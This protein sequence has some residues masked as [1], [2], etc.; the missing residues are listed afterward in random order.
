M[1]RSAA[2]VNSSPDHQTNILKAVQIM[3]DQLLTLKPVKLRSN[4][5]VTIPPG[6]TLELRGPV[7]TCDNELPEFHSLRVSARS[8][9]LLPKGLQVSSVQLKE[10][11]SVPQVTV[12][13]QNLNPRHSVQVHSDIIFAELE[14]ERGTKEETV[15]PQLLEALVGPSCESPVAINDIDTKCLLDSG[16]QVTVLSEQFYRK[17]LSHFPLKDLDT[18]LHITG[19]GGQSVPYL[20]IVNVTLTLPKTVA[21]TGS[22][23]NTMVFVC[24]DTDFSARVPLIVGTNVFRTLASMEERKD[25]TK[26]FDNLPPTLKC[27]AAFMYTDSISEQGSSGRL[28]PVRLRGKDCVIPA[29][30]TIDVKGFS[31]VTVP[32]TRDSVLIQEPVIQTLPSGLGVVS[33][34]VNVDDLFHVK[35]SLH[36][37]SDHDIVLRKK[38][39]IADVFNISAEY[40]VDK[41][42]S[43]LNHHLVGKNDFSFQ[44]NCSLSAGD[45]T[46]TTSEPSLSNSKSHQYRF[47]E[48]TPVDWQ[49]SFSHRLT[50]YQDVFIKHD[51]D[52]GC[53]FG[54]EHDIELTPG[55]TIRERPRPVAP[56][57]LEE[58]KKHIQDLLD[59]QIISPSTSSFASPIVL[60]RKKSGALRMCVDY[61]KLNARTMKDAYS[62][63]KIED[64]FLTLSGAK[65]FTSVDLSKA[66]YQVPMTDRAKQFSAFTT[67]LGLFQWERMSMGLTNAPATF[68]RLMETV[69][70]DMNLMELIV[71]LDD[72]LIHGKTLEE[73][74]ERT[75]NV[76][77]RLR[78]FNLKLDPAKCIFGATEVKHLGYIVSDEGIRPDP[79]KLEA[80]KTWP[81]PKTVKELKSFLGFASFYRRFVNGFARIAKPLHELTSGYTPQKGKKGRQKSTLTLSS[82]ISH[83]IEPKHQVAFRELVTAL[84]SAPILGIADKSNPFELHCD[85]SGTGLGAVLYQD[86]GDGLKVIAYAS[87]GLT[88][89]EQNYP[90][91]KREFLALK[92]AMSE[93]FHDYLY[94]SP[95]TVVTD[96]NPLC[97]VL[98]NAKLD[99]TSHRWLTTLSLYDFELRYK[100]GALHQDADG[101][102]RRPQPSPEED[103]EYRKTLEKSAFL[104]KKAQQFD[105]E[106]KHQTH[107]VNVTR[108]IIQAILVAKG[109]TT[110]ASCHQHRVSCN[111]QVDAE[112]CELNNWS[113]AVEQIIK[114][115][116]KIEDHVLE[117]PIQ[118]TFSLSPDEWKTLQRADKTLQLVINHVERGEKLELHKID[119]VTPELRVFARE[120]GKLVL[121]EGVLY[122]KTLKEANARLQLVIPSSHRA[123]AMKGVHDDLF[124]TH[125]EDSLHQA[126]LRFYWPFMARDLERK[127]KRCSRCIRRGAKFQKAPMHSIVT[128]FPLE[129]LSIDFLTIEVKGGKQNILVVMDHFTKF[130][131][132]ILTK[133]QTAKTVA[134]ALWN[135]FFMVYGF[136]MRILSDQGRDFE[137]NLIK[138][139]CSVAGIQ[140]CRTSP[141]HP[142]SNPVERWNR[143]LITM[144]RS[145]EDCQKTDW[146]KHIKSCVH[147]YNA[148]IHQSTGY[149]PYYLFFGR[150]PRLPIDLAFG[151]ETVHGST[152]IEYIRSLKD[153][154]KSAYQLA[155]DN[156]AK[157]AKRNK[158]RYDAGAHAAELEPGDRVLVKKLGPKITSKVDDRWERS[159]YKI[160]SKSEDL[161]VYVVEREDGIG[162]RR[163]LHRNL[164]LPIG[165]LELSESEHRHVVHK[166]SR[167]RTVGIPNQEE[168][169]EEEM[170]QQTLIVEVGSA[171]T[172]ELRAEAP[173]FVP[174]SVAGHDSNEENSDDSGQD[175]Q[176]VNRSNEEG[177]EGSNRE[178]EAELE[179]SESRCQMAEQAE[180]GGEEK[181]GSDQEEKPELEAS[182]SR[183]RRTEQAEEGE[184]E[185]EEGEINQHQN[186]WESEEEENSVRLRRSTRTR[187]PV[188]R[189]NLGHYCR[190]SPVL[191]EKT[192]SKLHVCMSGKLPDEAAFHVEKA[193]HAIL[194]MLDTWF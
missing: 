59:A 112:V 118:R 148:C 50:Q 146:R 70:R 35:V 20:G 173:E 65:Y 79:E 141:Y 6:D 107:Q 88:K 124:H 178:E 33:R 144:L 15:T 153:N 116:S 138:E 143:T 149:S 7:T 75:I 174:N 181:E 53:T 16:S 38:Q 24:K 34:K 56:K 96:N 103:E 67:P 9:D 120:Q 97:Y 10:T 46:R 189:L 87:R 167:N 135:D 129:L 68:Q 36:N 194:Q 54:A 157:M 114:D 166:N 122:R 63:P 29:G 185:I 77:E 55:L 80:L 17:H 117:P 100:R 42:F 31:H 180:E 47:G 81:F 1:G 23:V 184:E 25:G 110:T 13:L 4:T 140:K 91:H 160:I 111:Q 106:L 83:L 171:P 32:C 113:P 8:A 41:V 102:S 177:K 187:K 190:V 14:I 85:A 132:A 156:M 101:L 192:I 115:P 119:I 186:P 152:S 137:S 95:V 108:D 183:C 40:A 134:K 45:R 92:W 175:D 142:C 74:E 71:F 51:F 44:E 93:K 78:K 109:A 66:Y 164:L 193:L 72:I 188:E 133:D 27:E 2:K 39:V 105:D 57:D 64:L 86:Q 104:I 145:L 98:K 19:A 123:E 161:P 30:E 89:T 48:K 3:E 82:D 155:A 170:D 179:A 158:L 49:Q 169:E 90:A 163:T 43:V 136:P 61:R 5:V 147:A 128:T 131:Q 176:T 139:L 11:T 94:G 37:M 121:H 130:A 84:M 162:P 150:Q 151:I 76:L 52:V 26:F 182:E 12:L 62:I 159:I 21:G 18:D 28:G 168:E 125:L 127:L 73:L 60:V 126:R 191:M 165:A 69:F 22:P 58:V 172:K 154:L 99:A